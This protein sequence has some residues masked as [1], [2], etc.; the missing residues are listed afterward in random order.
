ME[1]CELLLCG[2]CCTSWVQKEPEFGMRTGLRGASGPSLTPPNPWTYDWLKKPLSMSRAFSS[3]ETS[4][5]RGVS[6]NIF[7]AIRCMP[8]SSA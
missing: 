7:S 2:S 3:A 4:T 5:L 8:P 1:A 6:R